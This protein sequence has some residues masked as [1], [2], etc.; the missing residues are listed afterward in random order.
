MTS[1]TFFSDRFNKPVILTY[2]A[3]EQMKERGVDDDT[4]FD[5]LESGQVLQK[6]DEHLWIYKAFQGRKDNMLCVAAL[7]RK[8]LIVKTVM[9]HW[10][11]SDEY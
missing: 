1:N 8:K 11:L 6:D 4:L 5:L 9:I 7:E 3:I 10:E 2:H